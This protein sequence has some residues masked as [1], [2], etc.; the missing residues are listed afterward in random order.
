[1]LNLFSSV[2]VPNMPKS[3][4]F[5]IAIYYCACLLF[6]LE[7]RNNVYQKQ[8]KKITRGLYILTEIGQMYFFVAMSFPIL[9]NTN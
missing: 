2:L 3:R 1:M 4:H 9:K 5:P 6:F 8:G 7:E